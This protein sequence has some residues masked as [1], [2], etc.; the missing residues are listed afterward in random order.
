MSTR[1]I[2]LG[3]FIFFMLGFSVRGVFDSE[4]TAHAASP[5]PHPQDSCSYS[6]D[7]GDAFC[8]TWNPQKALYACEPK[9]YS[10]AVWDAACIDKI[11]A[12]D[13][14][15]IE[16]PLVDQEPDRKHM[17]ASG[18]LVVKFKPGC[19]FHYEVRSR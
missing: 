2:L 7:C 15:R 11:E 9:Q 14:A 10:V 5:V 1:E 16:A 12:G 8:K 6:S 3:L 19:T 13:K 17:T 4:L 18:L